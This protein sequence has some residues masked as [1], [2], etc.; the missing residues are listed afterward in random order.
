MANDEQPPQDHQPQGDQPTTSGDI[1]TNDIAGQGIAVGHGA[2]A[3]HHEGSAEVQGDNPGQNVGINYGT[4]MQHLAVRLSIGIGVALI[5][6]VGVLGSAVIWNIG[7][8][9]P[10]ARD[11]WQ[12]VF[13]PFPAADEGESLIIVADFRDASE[14]QQAGSNPASFLYHSLT[15]RV[16]RDG[17]EVRVERL[18]TGLNANTARQ[19]GEVYHATLVLWGEY[20]RTAIILN[21]ERIQLLSQRLSDE[22]GTPLAI[23]DPERIQIGE[24]TDIAAM[25]SYVTLYTLGADRYA[26]GEYDAARDY[27]TSA[28]NAVPDDAELTAQPDEA[29]FLRGNIAL[30]QEQ[31]YR[32]A[33]HDYEAALELNPEDA[34]ILNNL[35]IALF[36]LGEYTQARA[37]YEQSLARRDFDDKQGRAQTLMNLGNIASNLGQYPEAIVYSEQALTLFRELEDQHGEAD[38]LNNLGNISFHQGEYVQAR[39]YYEQSFTITHNLGDRQGEARSLTNLGLVARNMGEPVRARRYYEQALVLFRELGNRQGEATTLNNLSIL[40]R[41]QGETAQAHDY[42]EQALALFHKLEDRQGEA[43]SLNNLGNISF[44]QG[45]YAQ[46]RQYYEQSQAIA[47]ELDDKAGIARTNWNLG[48][49][50]EAQG[51]LERAEDLIQVAVELYMTIEHTQN[52]ERALEDLERVQAHLAE[53]GE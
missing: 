14:G 10:I 7:P 25:S 22:E 12:Q 42:C 32:A 51:D 43:R 35:G 9:S 38:T 2:K 31:E 40:F 4:M 21:L 16:E 13:P 29:Y 36:H 34:V 20:N 45:E 30:W 47:H 24:L 52:A 6:T 26:I 1:T 37:Y 27:L 28:I 23:Y 53:Q 33:V 11:V 41:N 18:Y 48:L 50:Y 39:E 15:D 8:L 17:L 46:A 49:L 19:T 44:H 5:L 3:T